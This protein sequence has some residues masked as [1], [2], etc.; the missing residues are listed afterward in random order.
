MKKLGIILFGLMLLTQPLQ[1][2][3]WTP[4]MAPWIADG[5]TVTY[6][7]DGVSDIAV[8]NAWGYWAVPTRQ[9]RLAHQPDGHRLLR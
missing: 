7:Y 8:G 6:T 9:L 5:A 4:T 1:A 2:Q 3:P